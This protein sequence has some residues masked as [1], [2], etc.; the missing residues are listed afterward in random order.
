MEQ[1]AREEGEERKTSVRSLFSLLLAIAD[2][3]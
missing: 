1:G 2:V 3:A